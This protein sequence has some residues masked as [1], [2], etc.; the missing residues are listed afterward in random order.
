M[1]AVS[2]SIA[3][4]LTLW[5]AAALAASPPATQ[6]HS[7][8]QDLDYG[9]GLYHYY[10]GD[11]AQALTTLEL[12]NQRGGMSGHGHYPQLMRAGMY[13]AYGM[14]E[15]ARAEFSA[16]LGQGEP[17]PV[18]DTAHY[19]LARLSYQARDYA[20]ARQHLQAVGEALPPHLSDESALLAVHLR[21]QQSGAPSLATAA[22]LLEPLADNRY[23]ALLNLGNSAARGGDPIR[24]QSYYRAML[25]EDAPEDEA[26]VDEYLAIRDKVYTALGYSYLEQRDYASAKAA[27]RGVRLDTSL[28]NRALLGYGWAAASYHDYVLALKPWQA[29]RQR[30]L[31]DPA[32][33]ESLI[34]VPWAYEQIDSTGAALGAY[35]ESELLLTAEL[36]ELDAALARMSGSELLAHLNDAESHPSLQW[37][38]TH[39]RQNWLSLDQVSVLQSDLTYLDE[40]LISDDFQ[41][42]VQNLRDLLGLADKLQQW[43][44]KLV[45]YTQLWEDKRQRR[46]ER[47]AQL[48]QQQTLQQPAALGAAHREQRQRLQTLAQERNAMALATGDTAKLWLRLQRAEQ[49]FSQLQGQQNLP[50]DTA[51]K[52]QLY[53]GILRWRAHEQFAHN[54]WQVQK[55]L[56]TAEATLAEA[57]ER[58]TRIQS[59]LQS[60]PDIDAGLAALNR[61]SARND[62]ELAALRQAIQERGNAL[63]DTLSEH[64]SNH[65]VRL[66]DYLAQ[67]RL[68]IARLLDDAY[69]ADPPSDGPQLPEVQP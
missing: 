25:D 22:P 49:S 11:F 38:D 33:Q 13:L 46:V 62:R 9:E 4:A 17:E 55:P 61:L 29:L 60:E 14:T 3:L 63:A 32:V 34:A 64:L 58:A 31:L 36:A 42:R 50:P 12:A 54:L 35:R 24:A 23:L 5:G 40:L 19:Y 16:H 8:A 7:A 1:G 39:S 66:N 27:F 37:G 44:N 52:L 68:S 21:I 65:R 59:L 28:A 57:D 6:T 69:R 26:R 67:T 56:T 45:I 43:Q 15:R 10:Q 47:A 30:S 51:A 53:R 41:A 2:H 20:A 48:Q 18:R